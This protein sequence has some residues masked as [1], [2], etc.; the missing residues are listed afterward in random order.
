MHGEI[1]SSSV[2]K[3]Y[4]AHVLYA[5]SVD[6]KSFTANRVSYK[7][8]SSNRL[9]DSYHVGNRYPEGE[10]VRVYYMPDNPRVCVLEPGIKQG[11]YFMPGTGLLFLVVG[12]LMAIFSK[13]ITR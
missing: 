12:S 3:P 7:D 1:I 10:D 4:A 13:K 9:S 2:K 6:G 11:A 8:Y 5:F